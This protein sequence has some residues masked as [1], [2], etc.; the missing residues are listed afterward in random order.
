[1][2]YISLFYFIIGHYP[3]RIKLCSFPMMIQSGMSAFRSVFPSSGELITLYG[4]LV[5]YP[6]Q[7]FVN[8]LVIF[9]CLCKR[10]IDNF[11]VQYAYHQILLLFHQSMDG[12]F[13]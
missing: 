6:N 2:V 13:S 11:I 4:Q 7:A 1:M 9:D 5:K 3:Y 12:C 10:N 8:R